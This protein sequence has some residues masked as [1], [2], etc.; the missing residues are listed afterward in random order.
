MGFGT[1]DLVDDVMRA[2][3]RTIRVFLAYQMGCV[4]CPLSCFHTVTDACREHRID[5][6][7]FLAAL[8]DCTEHDSD[9]REPVLRNDHAQEGN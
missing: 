8:R 5:R 2:E 7:A 9:R 1:D 6:D 3:P 4:G